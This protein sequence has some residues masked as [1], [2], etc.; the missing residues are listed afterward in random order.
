MYSSVKGT[1]FFVLVTGDILVL[2]DIGDR[3]RDDNSFDALREVFEHSDC[4]A[5]DRVFVVGHSLGEAR[6]RPG[7]ST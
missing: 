4:V 1:L 2:D 3:L 5:V 6:K 7:R